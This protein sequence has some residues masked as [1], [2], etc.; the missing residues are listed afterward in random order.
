[1]SDLPSLNQSF[2]RLKEEVL[3]LRQSATATRVRPHKLV[4]LLAVLDLAEDG[5]LDENKNCLWRYAI[6]VLSPPFRRDCA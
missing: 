6:K 5:A 2:E 1:M 4:M 3:A